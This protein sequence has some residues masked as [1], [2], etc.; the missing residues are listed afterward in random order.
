DVFQFSRL[1]GPRER[2]D[3]VI[4]GDHSKIAMTCFARMHEKGRCSGGCEG[5]SNLASDV[6]GLSHTGH[7]DSALRRADDIDGSR[8]AAAKTVVQ[9]GGKC[10]NPASFGL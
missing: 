8:K 4:V 7:N 1:A 2:E 9:C 10:V 3:D 5:R 6:A